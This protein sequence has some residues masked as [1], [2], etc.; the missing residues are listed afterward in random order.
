MQSVLDESDLSKAQ[1]DRYNGNKG[2]SQDLNEAGLNAASLEANRQDKQLQQPPGKSQSQQRFDS[3]WKK[4]LDLREEVMQARL[5]L[6]ELGLNLREPRSQVRNLHSQLLTSWQSHWNRGH[7]PDGDSLTTIYEKMQ[8]L[9]DDIGPLEEAYSEQE[10][11]LHVLEYRLGETEKKLYSKTVVLNMDLHSDTSPSSPNEVSEES[12]ILLP[13][14][15]G[16]TTNDEAIQRYLDRVGDANIARERVLILRQ[17]R[18]E[19]FGTAQQRLALGVPQYQP[20]VEFLEEFEKN[21]ELRVQE[22]NAINEDLP[23][24]AAAAGIDNAPENIQDLSLNAPADPWG[25]TLRATWPQLPVPAD[26]SKLRR[27]LSDGDLSKLRKTDTSSF[28]ERINNWILENLAVSKLEQ[29]HQHLILGSPNLQEHEWWDLVLRYWKQE[30]VHSYDLRSRPSPYSTQL[31]SAQR[32]SMFGRDAE[33]QLLSQPAIH[34]SEQQEI[35]MV[36][37]PQLA[38]KTDFAGSKWRRLRS[39]SANWR[40]PG[41]ALEDLDWD[42]MSDCETSRSQ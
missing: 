11:E 29:F 19:Y 28:R 16:G 42:L 21:Y 10:D 37:S 23:Q 4:M 32:S 25:V 39:V 36:N 41:P 26:G 38:L 18:D 14:F 1:M 40:K 27:T 7:E 8:R 6:R 5:T 13:T 12:V 15:S 22:M 31:N 35:A 24:L 30:S 2:R 17:E 3:A 9:L 34:R 33:T 20:N